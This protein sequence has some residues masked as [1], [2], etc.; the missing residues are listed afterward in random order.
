MKA[1]LELKQTRDFGE[2]ISDT[3]VF[4]RQNW[5]SL[6]KNYF[7]FCGFFIIGN[8]VFSIMLREK[9]VNMHNAIGIGGV[10]SVSTVFGFEYFMIIIFGYLNI[11][12][13]MLCT[14]CYISLYNEH[15]KQAPQLNQV[16]AYYKYYFWRTIGHSVL[17][18][19]IFV[20]GTLIFMIPFYMVVNGGNSFLTAGIGVLCLFI[21]WIYFLTIFSL[22]FPIVIIE[23]GSFAYAFGRCFKLIR[24]RWWNTFG[25]AV[26]IVIM[27]YA[28]FLLVIMP[29][30]IASGGMVNFL[31]YN[32]SKPVMIIYSVS[33]GLCQVLNILPL[34][35]MAITYFSYA[36]EKE[37]LGLLERIGSLGKAA[38]NIDTANEEY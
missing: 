27:V 26:V 31:S 14:L 32:V 7:V 15:G 30:S 25:V 8:I 28:G 16:W 24:K 10:N 33:L 19:L 23:N 5:K 3:I 22:F 38:E 11:M 17:F 2:I 1:R 35:A 36:D 12:S 20:F 13:A 6:I 21:P 34:V 4:I 9:L 18:F 37:S 29:F